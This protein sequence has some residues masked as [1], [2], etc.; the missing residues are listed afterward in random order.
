MT[1]TT[2]TQHDRG[3]SSVIATALVISITVLLAAVLGTSLLGPA[4]AVLEDP[5]PQSSL[6]MDVSADTNE[7]TIRL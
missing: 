5:A 3:I 4:T 1:A 7:I 2:R 6:A